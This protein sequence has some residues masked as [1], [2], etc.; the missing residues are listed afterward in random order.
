MSAL[1]PFAGLAQTQMQQ[2]LQQIQQSV[3]EVHL[4]V[5]WK[6]GKRTESL[7]VVNDVFSLRQG[8]DRNGTPGQAL[9]TT[10][11]AVQGAPGA[12]VGPGLPFQ[13]FP[14]RLPGQP[15]P[16]GPTT[17]NTPPG[18]PLDPFGRPIR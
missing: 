2:L 3:R 12:Q 18:T 6:D 15:R 4:T 5:S 9:S 13:G 1:G 16:V 10:P 11:G 17:G 8:S 14:P 7:D